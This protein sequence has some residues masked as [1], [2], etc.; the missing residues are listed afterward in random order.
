MISE[1]SPAGMNSRIA[2][3]ANSRRGSEKSNLIDG[4]A[5]VIFSSGVRVHAVYCVPRADFPRGSGLFFTRYR[6]MNLRCGV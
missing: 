2:P 4:S 1:R 5:N 3:F 6:I